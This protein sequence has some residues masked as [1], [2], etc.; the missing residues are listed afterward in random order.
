MLRWAMGLLVVALVTTMFG[1]GGIFFATEALRT[2]FYLFVV[3]LLAT[4]LPVLVSDR[5]NNMDQY[6][7]DRRPRASRA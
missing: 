3:V 2:L 5:R 7:R 4:I 6:R 1:A